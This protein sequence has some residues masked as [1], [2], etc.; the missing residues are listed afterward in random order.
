MACIW[1]FRRIADFIKLGPGVWFETCANGI[2]FKD[3]PDNDKEQ[4]G[5]NLH[6]FR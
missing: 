1:T 2:I 6:H 5:T 3:G 4:E